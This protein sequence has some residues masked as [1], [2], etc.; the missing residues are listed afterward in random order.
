VPVT[1]RTGSGLRSNGT[2]N[3]LIARFR[4]VSSIAPRIPRPASRHAPSNPQCPLFESVAGAAERL[5]NEDI[6]PEHNA[7]AGCDHAHDLAINGDDCDLR[8][9]SLDYGEVLSH[10]FRPLLHDEV[11]PVALEN[12]IARIEALLRDSLPQREDAVL[13]GPENL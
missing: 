8:V 13:A 3:S 4:G 11:C 10:N 5:L 2:Q 6:T 12:K 7:I 9:G 1:T